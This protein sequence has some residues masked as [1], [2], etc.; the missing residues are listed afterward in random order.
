M[1][2]GLATL[3]TAGQKSFGKGIL[4]WSTSLVFHC[5]Q[6]L[7]LVLGHSWLNTII[8]DISKSQNQKMGVRETI[9]IYVVPTI[10]LAVIIQL[11]SEE[12]TRI[13]KKVVF[14]CFRI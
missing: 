8:T 10:G 13:L 14:K 6:E 7:N 2:C 5:A 9:H 1:L 11:P 4:L 12:A 3:R